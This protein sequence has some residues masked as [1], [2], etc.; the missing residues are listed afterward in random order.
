MYHG[1]SV[2]I[3][4]DSYKVAKMTWMERLQEVGTM[5]EKTNNF[6]YSPYIRKLYYKLLNA[7]ECKDSVTT[8]K[9]IV[10]MGF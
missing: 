4:S 10:R 5:A 3:Q 6:S 1:N 7:C 8:K 2:N 9:L